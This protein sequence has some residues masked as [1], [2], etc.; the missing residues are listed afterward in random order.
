MTNDTR[1]LAQI[2]IDG[3]LANRTNDEIL[4]E[5]FTLHPENS[6]KDKPTSKACVAWYRTHLRNNRKV[7]LFVDATKGWTFDKGTGRWSRTEPQAPIEARPD[8]GF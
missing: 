8:L 2:Q 1:T 5:I 3:I 4:A 7:K 6:K